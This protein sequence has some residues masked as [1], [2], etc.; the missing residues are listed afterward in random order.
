MTF[1]LAL[2][3]ACAAG[4][5]GA[6]AAAPRLVTML[7]VHGFNASGQLTTVGTVDLAKATIAWSP[8]FIVADQSALSSFTAA[9]ALA[10]DGTTPTYVIPTGSEFEAG[11]YG[12][13]TVSATTGETLHRVTA[14]D[15]WDVPFFEAVRGS[16]S[17]LVALGEGGTHPL[18]ALS[19]DSVTGA[20]RVIDT[21]D[22]LEFISAFPPGVSTFVSA[23]GANGTLVFIDAAISR[24]NSNTIVAF[25]VATG[26]V[27]ANTSVYAGLIQ[28]VAGYT[29]PD[30]TPGLVAL[31]LPNDRT[32]PASIVLLDALAPAWAPRTLFEFAVGTTPMMATAGIVGTTLIAIAQDASSNLLVVADLE[33]LP[34]P[35]TMLKVSVRPVDITSVTAYGV[36]S[37]GGVA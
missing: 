3:V 5:T 28:S 22:D 35:G 30:G 25:D 14:S 20:V 26:R 34:P 9:F 36:G 17:T 15:A 24:N 11:K 32:A 37:I 18:S 10:A 19:V 7:G 21:G 12:Y 6:A 31:L 33:V 13:L 16:A 27:V 4:H 23:A 8:L 29:Q 2:L 1:R